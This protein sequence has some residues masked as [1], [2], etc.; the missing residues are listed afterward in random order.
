MWYGNAH[1]SK[2]P[3]MRNGIL[4][5]SQGEERRCLGVLHLTMEDEARR[6]NAEQAI[7]DTMAKLRQSRTPDSRSSCQQAPVGDP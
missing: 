6:L 1:T 3:G 4:V 5:I 7:A 2:G